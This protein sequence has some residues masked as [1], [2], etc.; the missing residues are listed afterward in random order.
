MFRL[1]N[2]LKIIDSVNISLL[3]INKV[4][5]AG[6]EFKGI[7]SNIDVNELIGGSK[8]NNESSVKIKENISNNE[9]VNN[10]TNKFV[11]TQESV[12][13]N[14]IKIDLKDKT[15]EEIDRRKK[16]NNKVNEKEI[17]LEK[18]VISINIH[19][20]KNN[21][22]VTSQ[23]NTIEN[24]SANKGTLK[25]DFVENTK[26]LNININDI[27][28]NELAI[29]KNNE[30]DHNNNADNEERRD[31]PFLIKS[32]KLKFT[33]KQSRIPV[34][35]FSRAMNFGFMGVSMLGNTL[36]QAIIDKVYY[37]LN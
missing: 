8:N 21:L 1:K 30:K 23:N 14:N 34:S 33:G 36:T 6:K 5:G 20:S 22:E 11:K 28:A 2:V 4:A 27:A 19:D 29:K 35:S 26:Y 10:S 7:Y 15:Q 9:M 37:I 32:D 24:Q 16:D 31:E 18:N 12:Q 25:N 17:N 3:T 13:N